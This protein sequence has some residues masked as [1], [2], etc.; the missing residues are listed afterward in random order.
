M[1]VL[2]ILLLVT[3]A[4]A[5]ALATALPP[6]TLI[7]RSGDRYSIDGPIREENGR[8]IFRQAGGALYSL[9]LTEVDV[10]ATRAAARPPVPPVVVRPQPAPAAKEQ[11]L[12]V[13]AEER[14]R[15]LRELEKNHSG[16]P[17]PPQKSLD[18]LPPPPTP[19]EVEAAK[20]D[21]WSWRH[22][23]RDYE[24]AVRRAEENLEL[25]HARVNQLEQQILGFTSLGYHPRQFTYQTTELQY[26]RDSIPAAELEVTRAKRA[27]DQF[28]DDARRQGILPGWLR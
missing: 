3:T 25:L 9:L 16:T 5:T 15:M 2:R 26:A 14:D 18:A 22:R 28:R 1:G 23:A 21:E 11:K 4:M 19:R 17:A 12:K 6:T 24:E 10:E 20:Q 8:V 7:L 27:W 13:S